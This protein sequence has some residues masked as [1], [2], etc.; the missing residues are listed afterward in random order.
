MKAVVVEALLHW[1]YSVKRPVFS[2]AQPALRVPSP[3]TFLGAL[4]RSKAYID[5]LPEVVGGEKPYSS[6]VEL[7]DV[8][9]WA[10]MALVDE[11]YVNPVT[12]LI[13]THDI[14]RAVIAPYLRRENVYPGSPMLFGPQ[15][16][17][18]I[19]APGMRVE[20][21]YLVRRGDVLRYAYGIMALGSK[22]SIVSVS[23]AREV[24]VEEAG[25]VVETRFYF[26][27]RLASKV[28]GNYLTETLSS[29]HRDHYA[30]A[31][32]KDLYVNWEEYVVPIRPVRVTPSGE[33]AVLRD[34]EERVLL[35]PREV[36]EG[37]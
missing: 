29:P 26:P 22:E 24:D 28:E 37:G 12:G 31:E 2:A 9:P 27:R 21:V 11:D 3:T 17:G 13:E 14:L 33:A 15:P 20:V 30:V 16:H 34:S 36:V 35:V 25:G 4:A 8:V 18:K 1:G 10:S 5:K 6:T 32:V 7:L 19:Y 23:S